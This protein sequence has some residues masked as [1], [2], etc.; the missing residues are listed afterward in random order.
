MNKKRF[1]LRTVF[2]SAFTAAVYFPTSEVVTIQLY[3]HKDPAIQAYVEQNLEQIIEKQEKKIGITYPT[4]R[5]KI[6]YTFLEKDISIGTLGLYD[7]AGNIIYL[8]SGILTTP[9]WDFGDF[10]VT[11]GTFNR[12][13]DVKII[14]NHE[15]T[16]FYCDKIKEKALGKTYHL[17]QMRLFIPTEFIAN[18]LI[19]EGIATYIETKTNDME[20]KVISFNQWPLTVEQFSDYEIYHGGYALVKPIIDQYGE[21]G[22]QFLLFN[23]PTSKEVFTPKEYQKRVLNDLA[24]L[25]QK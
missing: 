15:L 24:K 19:N 17:H 16:H 21:K 7:N 20:K 4:E 23:I 6:E 22:I 10:L 9:K 12:T 8:P 14:L 13:A 5:P 1:I 18:Q 3:Y 11:V 25:Y 2:W